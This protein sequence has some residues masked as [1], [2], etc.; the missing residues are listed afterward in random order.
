MSKFLSRSA[1]VLASL[2]GLSIPAVAQQQQFFTIGSGSTTGLYYPTAVG[3]AKIVNEANVGVRA[4]ARSTGGSVFNAK[5]IG[6]GQMQMGF[7]QNNVAQY[8]YK[9]E[10]VEAFKGAAV[11]NLRGVAALYPEVVHLLARKDANIKSPADLSGKR[12]YV[13]DVGSGT[14]ADADNVLSAYGLNLGNLQ[15]TIR[16]SAGSAVNLLRDGR[17]DAMFYTVGVGASAITEAAQTTPI[18]VVPF[19]DDKLAELNKK[20]PFYTAFTIPGGTYPEL[21][22][23]VKTITLKAML[24][25][26]AS[27][28]E[29][30]V[31]QFTKTLFKDKLDAF[32][33]EIQNPNLKTYFKVETALEG[34]PIPL[35]PGAAK[36]F[37]EAGVQIPDGIKPTAAQ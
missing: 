1:L 19:S 37:Q 33:G 11:K 4:N 23:D 13:G 20:F 15:S 3:M 28:P 7:M 36:F 31:Y 9:G 30:A 35:H 27:I 2:M 18:V 14:E 8:A 26:D 25:T 24:A 10:G 21:A 34:M 29:E 16:G 12:V 17:I 6:D 22:D 5:A 32:Y